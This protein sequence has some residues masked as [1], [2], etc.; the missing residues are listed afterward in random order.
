MKTQKL[1]NLLNDSSN[2]E[3]KCARKKKENGMLQ[4]VKHQ[5]INTIKRILSNL[6]YKV[7]DQNFVIILIH[8]L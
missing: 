7:L 6:K 8:L 3:S 1:I 5:K 4:T 2:E